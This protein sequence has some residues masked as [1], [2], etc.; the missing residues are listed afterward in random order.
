MPLAARHAQALAM[1][2]TQETPVGSQGLLRCLEVWRYGGEMP[3]RTT[4]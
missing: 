3:P 2:L 1:K 4:T